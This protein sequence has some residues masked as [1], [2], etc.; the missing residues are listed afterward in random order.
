MNCPVSRLC[1]GCELLQMSYAKQARIKQEEVQDLVNKAGLK[2]EVQPVQMA[3]S[4]IGYRNKVIYGFAKDKA[5]S[6]THLT[7][8]T[9]LRV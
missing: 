9:I 2:I 5:V 3:E 1:G 8:P 4:A 7:L 6:Y